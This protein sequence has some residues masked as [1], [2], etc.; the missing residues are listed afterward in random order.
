MKKLLL[1]AALVFVLVSTAYA[2]ELS[3]IVNKEKG[4]IIIPAEV[5]G[6]YFVTPTKHALSYYKGGNG[7]KSIMRALVSEIDYYNAL[8]ELGAIPGN[9]IKA[10]DMKAKSSAEGKSTEGDKLSA[11]VTWE[12][13]N[14]EIPLDDVVVSEVANGGKVRPIDLRFSG[15]FEFAKRS[16]PGCFI[17]LDSCSAGISTNAAWPTGALNNREVSFHGNSKVLPPDGTRVN[18]IVRLVK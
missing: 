16:R 2:E 6:K 1:F 7:P 9:N 15:N 18:V 3:L 4:E 11:F 12:G 14:G 17:C 13:S 10:E 5:N 8:A